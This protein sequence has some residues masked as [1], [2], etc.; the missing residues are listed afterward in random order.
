[1]ESILDKLARELGR[2]GGTVLAPQIIP[3]AEIEGGWRDW[4][5]WANRLYRVGCFGVG[6]VL[7]ELSLLELGLSTL[8][9]AFLFM[10]LNFAAGLY[11]VTFPGHRRISFHFILT[12]TNLLLFGPGV[13]A[14]AS[15]AGAFGHYLIFRQKPLSTAMFQMGRFMLAAMGAGFIFFTTGGRWGVANLTWPSVI[16]SAMAY[17]AIS[18]LLEA[19]PLLW[20]R[21]GSLRTLWASFLW[22]PRAYIIFVPTS[23]CIFYI[24][25]P[26]GPDGVVLFLIPV[27]TFI[28]ALE[29]YARSA[30]AGQNLTIIQEISR[31]FSSFLD[32]DR[33]IAEALELTGRVIN[34][35]WAVVWLK[36]PQTGRLEI[37]YSSSHAGEG[38]TVPAEPPEAVLRTVQTGRL[39][40]FSASSLQAE[41]AFGEPT[42][43]SVLAVPLSSRGEVLGVLSL[44]TATPKG[45]TSRERLLLETLAGNVAIAIQNAQLY[46]QRETEAIR[47]GLTRIYNRRFLRE[48]LILEEA[49]A[50]RYNRIFSLIILDIDHF[51][52]YN[53]N[54]GHP[55]GDHLLIDLAKILVRS[56]REVDFVARYGG[57][58]FAIVLPECGKESAVLVAQRLRKQVED[59]SNPHRDRYNLTVSV[60]VA[61]FPED[62]NEKG[63]VLDKADQA[64]Y[65]AKRDGR[66]RVCW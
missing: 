22:N 60:G 65:R 64:M 16:L 48:K 49:R 35:L 45:Y 25:F 31:G 33:L 66:N 42:S 4:R 12:Y 43:L 32:P 38:Q 15:G 3:Q 63:E 37:R 19:L 28:L 21:G 2:R 61:S 40:E 10:L 24:Y 62:G 51:K 59:F 50:K 39:V 53:D 14:L 44:G 55:A 8:K 27:A 52:V 23:I 47:D 58:E 18:F 17:L 20:S 57:E 34:F 54:F 36:N 46:K 29:L 5:W 41:N 6:I 13:A 30:I 11:T 56:V 7:M 9:A 26:Y 1:V